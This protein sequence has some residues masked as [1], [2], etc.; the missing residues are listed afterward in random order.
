M[1]VNGKQRERG[2]HQRESATKMR[3]SALLLVNQL[4]CWP[5][6]KQSKT[7]SERVGALCAADSR[8]GLRNWNRKRRRPVS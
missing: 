1:G 2:D 7:M 8:G 6:V 4:D 5:V 3:R